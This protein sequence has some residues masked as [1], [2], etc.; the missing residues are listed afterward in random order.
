MQILNLILI[1][2]II[3]LSVFGLF[4]W[5]L[6]YSSCPKEKRMIMVLPFWFLVPGIFDEQADSYEKKFIIIAVLA[7]ILVGAIYSIHP[8]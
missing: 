1:G 6:A 5:S 2:L 4:Y 8:I 7:I 3:L